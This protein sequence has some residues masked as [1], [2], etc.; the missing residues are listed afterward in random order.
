MIVFH[1]TYEKL[2]SKKALGIYKRLE[3]S[4]GFQ[5]CIQS[6]A[7]QESARNVLHAHLILSSSPVQVNLLWNMTQS[8]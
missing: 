8:Y 3:N 7:S 2:T 5:L 4:S 6:Y 1:A